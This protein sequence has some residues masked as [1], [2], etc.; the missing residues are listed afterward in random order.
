MRLDGGD[1]GDGP[2]PVLARVGRERFRVVPPTISAVNPIG[3][4]DC[5]LA[6]LVDARLLGRDPESTLRHGVA[7]AVANAEVWDA[8]AI[9]PAEVAR[10]GAELAVE[11]KPA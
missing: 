5:L 3:S 7:C 6:G 4:G 11:V 9:D 8:G 1:V 2:G 10:V